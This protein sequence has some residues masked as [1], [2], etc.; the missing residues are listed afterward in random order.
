MQIHAYLSFDGDCE[1]AMRHYADV[2]RG[3]IVAMQPHEGTPSADYVPPDWRNKI[4]HARLHAGDA[5]LMASDS[6]PGMQEKMRGI[7]VALILK[8]PAEAER[9]FNALAEDATVTM[10]LT[11]TFWAQKF[12]MLTDRFGTPW[13]INCEKPLEAQS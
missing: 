9:I 10:P 4:L 13:M 6:P 3:E 7:S 2:L 12:G 1:E 5:V 11:E 8:D